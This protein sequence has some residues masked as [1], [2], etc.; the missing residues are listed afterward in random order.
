[1]DLAYVSTVTR[2]ASIIDQ[3]LTMQREVMKENKE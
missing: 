2:I 3:E 1:M